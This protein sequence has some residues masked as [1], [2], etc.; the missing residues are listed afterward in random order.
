MFLIVLLD[1]VCS[2]LFGVCFWVFLNPFS[3]FF[4]SFLLFLKVLLGF[5]ISVFCVKVS[6]S[7]LIFLESGSSSFLISSAWLSSV[8]GLGSSFGTS[9]EL[10]AADAAA[11]LLRRFLF[12]LDKTSVV[13]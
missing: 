7:F 8:A 2:C 1:F 10:A 11:F 9:G 6:V 12:D 5:V 13:A 4:G 3:A